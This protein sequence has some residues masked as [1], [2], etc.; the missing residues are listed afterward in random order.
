MKF[1]PCD[2]ERVSTFV[3]Q[4]KVQEYTDYF[5]RLLNFNY[6]NKIRF[7]KHIEIISGKEL[8]NDVSDEINKK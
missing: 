7:G 6:N 4:M 3:N 2:D 5:F 8:L 1:L